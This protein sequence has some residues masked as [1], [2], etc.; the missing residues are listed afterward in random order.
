MRI[1]PATFAA[2]LVCGWSCL[3]GAEEPLFPFVISYDA[4]ENVTNVSAWLDRPAGKHGFVHSRDGHLATD[5]GPVRFWGTNLAFDACVPTH[6]QA[7]RV[8]ARLARLGINCVRIHHLDG[9][10][11]WG[12]SPNKLTIDPKRL[13]RLDYLIYQLKLHGVYTNLNLHVSRSL[14]PAEGFPHPELRPLF[15]KGVDQFEPRMIRLQQKYARDLLTHVNRYTRTAYTDEPAV[16]FV[17]ISNEDGLFA[18]WNS[19]QLDSL[20][21]PYATTFRNLWN[22]WLHRNTVTPTSSARRGPPERPWT[23]A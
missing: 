10:S 9:Y 1:L 19:G 5:A 20:P 18:Q 16:A 7:Q 12:Q 14:G 21:D 3:A 8:A 17:E 23:L 4:P 11:I 6:G 2:M 22:A 15:D 13:E